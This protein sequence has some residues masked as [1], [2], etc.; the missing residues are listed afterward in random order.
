M[1]NIESNGY[2]RFLM[3][4]NVD[5]IESTDSICIFNLECF[6]IKFLK[7]TIFASYFLRKEV[8]CAEDVYTASIH[9]F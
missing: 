6:A 3:L 2:A 1:L 9:S 8:N 7:R 5:R 4:V